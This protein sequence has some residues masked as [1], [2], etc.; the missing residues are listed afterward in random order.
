MFLFGMIF[1]Q[2]SVIIVISYEGFFLVF[3]KMGEWE[4]VLG[5]GKVQVSCVVFKNIIEN[6]FLG[7]DCV[8]GV[9]CF[10]EIVQFIGGKRCKEVVIVV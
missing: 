1:V 4:V 2:V 9:G 3:V 7:I 5:S 10:I 6:K 8:Y